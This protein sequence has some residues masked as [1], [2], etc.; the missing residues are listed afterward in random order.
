[1]TKNNLMDNLMSFLNKIYLFGILIVIAGCQTMPPHK[2]CYVADVNLHG[3]FNGD[4]KNGKAYGKGVAIGKDK[5]EGEFVNGYTH[6]QGTYTWGDD[7]SFNGQFISGVAQI[8]HVGCYVAD[9]R[10]RGKYSGECRDGKAHGHGKA[11]GI[12]VYEGNFLNGVLNGNGVY[13]WY[14]KDRY[15]GQLTNGKV[16]GRGVMRFID[17]SEKAGQ[18]INNQ[19]IN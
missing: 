16:H 2:D 3:Y 14:N 12:D 6:G 9:P 11:N 10:L 1:M 13:I 15:I 7:A 5:Y 4:C 18:W 19:P 17:G 8:A